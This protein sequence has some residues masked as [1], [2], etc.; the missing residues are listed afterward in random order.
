VRILLCVIATCSVP[1]VVAQQPPAPQTF[2]PVHVIAPPDTPLPPEAESAGISKFSFIAYGD[3]RSGSEPGVPGDG[4]ILQPRHSELVDGMLAKIKALAST[5]YPVRFVVQSGDAVL[6]GQNGAM[7]NVSFSPTIERLTRT[8]NVPYFF[9]VGNHDVTTMPPG[10]PSRA[11][12][13]HNALT[14]MSRLIPPEGSP[15]RLS[16]YPTYAFGYGNLFAIAIDSNIAADALQ[17]AWVTDELEHLDRSRYQHV[18]AFF[19]HPLFSSGPHGGPTLEPPSAAIR[20]LYAPLFRKHHV[21]MTIAGHDHLMDHWIERYTDHEVTY[22][23]DDV[24]TG[25]GGAPAY[26]YTDEPDLSAYIAAGAADNVRLEHLA[27]PGRSLEENPHHF[28]TVQ[29][30]GTKLSL[31]VIAIGDRPYAPYSGQSRVELNDRSGT[32]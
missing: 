15:R 13:L 2:V 23:R 19:H 28:V 18:M 11:L 7:W 8:G 29:V 30:D 25:G 6:R 5:P 4:Q 10:D 21:R 17:L 3:T 9:A 20:N 26:L 12:G 22:R 31:D 14:A 1:V 16:G 27:K 24:V 32:R